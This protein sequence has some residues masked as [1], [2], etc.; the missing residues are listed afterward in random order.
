MLRDRVLDYGYDRFGN[1]DALLLQDQTQVLNHEYPYDKLNRMGG[2]STPAGQLGL[3]GAGGV[4]I[5][6]LRFQYL[7]TD[8]VWKLTRANDVETTWTYRDMGPIS[9]IA[10]NDSGGVEIAR[11]RYTEF[12]ELG[13]VEEFTDGQG[14]H[15]FG[16]DEVFQLSSAVQP[17]QPAEAYSYSAGGDRELVASPGEYDYDANHRITKSPGSSVRGPLPMRGM[18]TETLIRAR[19]APTSNSIR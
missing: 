14:L 3:P 9:E 7:E 2:G 11:I 13:N 18:L 10:V 17:G 15:V 5:S 4:G 6:R 12:D 8:Y 16:Y 19:T 1:Q